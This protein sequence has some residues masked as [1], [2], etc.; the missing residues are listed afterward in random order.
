MNM[1][2]QNKFCFLDIVHYMSVDTYIYKST[3]LFSFGLLGHP[4]RA[5]PN[6]S[7]QSVENFQPALKINRAEDLNI[8]C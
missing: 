6:L 7:R 4:L 2:D 3:Y 1:I 5:L 8:W